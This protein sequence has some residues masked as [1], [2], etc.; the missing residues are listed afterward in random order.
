MALTC[1]PIGRGHI[2]VFDVPSTRQVGSVQIDGDI[3]CADVFQ[4]AVA[5]GLRSRALASSSDGRLFMWDPDAGSSPEEMLSEPAGSAVRAMHFV[6]SRLADGA[7]HATLLLGKANGQVVAFNLALRSSLPTFDSKWRSEP[8]LGGVSALEL[9]PEPNYSCAADPRLLIGYESGAVELVRLGG[10]VELSRSLHVMTAAA[11]PVRMLRAQLAC[12]ALGAG[13]RVVFWTTCAG[14]DGAFR[15][16]LCEVVAS[17]PAG[18]GNDGSIDVSMTSGGGSGAAAAGDEAEA[19][20]LRTL[21]SAEE[22]QLPAAHVLDIRPCTS[23]KARAVR[24]LALVLCSALSASALGSAEPQPQAQQQPS[25]RTRGDGRGEGELELWVVDVSAALRASDTSTPV[26]ATSML[27]RVETAAAVRAGG[28]GVGGVGGSGINSEPIGSGAAVQATRLLVGRH[29]VHDTFPLL[30]PALNGAAAPCWARALLGAARAAAEAEPL[31]AAHPAHTALPSVSAH[32]LLLPPVAAALAG[33]GGRAHGA[34]RLCPVRFESP[35]DAALRELSEAGV[36]ALD[37]DITTERLW[38]RCWHSGLLRGLAAPA[39]G[40]QGG[41]G[42]AGAGGEG[43]SA[44]GGALE[45]AGAS[46][47]AHLEHASQAQQSRAQFDPAAAMRAAVGGDTQSALSVARLH[48]LEVALRYHATCAAASAAAAADGAALSAL[49]L[50]SNLRDLARE[51]AAAAAR[52]QAEH[53]AEA[54]AAIA[55]AAEQAGE[56]QGELGSA[57]AE[58]QHASGARA[59]VALLELAAVRANNLCAALS[60]ILAADSAAAAAGALHPSAVEALGGVLGALAQRF[61]A[62]RTAAWLVGHG[63]LRALPPPT[64]AVDGGAAAAVWLRWPLRA[65]PSFGAYAHACWEEAAAGDMTPAEGAAGAALGSPAALLRLAAARPE[66]A[67]E[68]LLYCLLRAA[69]AD[70]APR[71]APFATYIAPAGAGGEAGAR[72]LRGLIALIEATH[73]A[74]GVGVSRARAI[75]MRALAA[76]DDGCWREACL[77]LLQPAACAANGGLGCVL[78]VAGALCEAREALE[79]RS[80]SAV[81]GGGREAA[82]AEAE[83]AELAEAACKLSAFVDLVALPTAE[84]EEADE[85]EGG[86]GWDAPPAQP[87]ASAHAAE[88]RRALARLCIASGDLLGAYGAVRGCADKGSFDWLCAQLSRQGKLDL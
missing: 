81:G 42:G 23:D 16:S 47:L 88:L 21:H 77:L 30:A 61:L 73:P 63:A 22:L 28:G 53:A 43:A 39:R 25:P 68:A 46:L 4:F 78:A 86:R 13:E 65:G 49:L 15:H 52:A 71:G 80:F 3:V 1:A 41:G 26:S 74:H 31:P 36:R 50:G 14:V 59:L 29:G 11:A 60:A 62:M 72:G 24:S 75:A 64:A 12:V 38:V 19:A 44:Y 83:A 58:A 70:G 48:L 87:R 18:G 76:A 9:L 54:L 8:S 10:T 2:A 55:E 40:A 20:Q 35:A 84:D 56:Q 34:A 45:A 69:R 57:A 32:V 82:E 37:D 51:W 27:C 33:G 67:S 5:A 6:G 17:A 66:R 7:D 79:E 85:D